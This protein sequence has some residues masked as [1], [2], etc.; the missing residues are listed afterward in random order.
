MTMARP[1]LLIGGGKGGVGKS[2]LSVAL[3]DYVSVADGRPFLIETDTSVPD[4]YKTY[5][6]H[7][8]PVHRVSRERTRSSYQLT[9]FSPG[10]LAKL[11]RSLVTT[12]WP[13]ASAVAAS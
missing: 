7:D 6:N 1:I 4:V 3:V 8:R 13:L 12:S 2:L 5:R 11:R 10:I 9:H